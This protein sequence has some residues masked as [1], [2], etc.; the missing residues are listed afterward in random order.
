MLTNPLSQETAREI[1]ALH[2]D[3]D[4][5][6]RLFNPAFPLEVLTPISIEESEKICQLK[7]TMSM[8]I[9][10][11][12]ALDGL[13]WEILPRIGVF[14]SQSVWSRVQ[15]SDAYSRFQQ[16]GHLIWAIKQPQPT[17]N[18]LLLNHWSQTVMCITEYDRMQGAR[19][20]EVTPGISGSLVDEAARQ[21]VFW[22]PSSLEMELRDQK[23]QVCAV[24]DNIL[25]GEVISLLPA[26]MPKS[27]WELIFLCLISS[28][29][30]K[31]KQTFFDTGL[32]PRQGLIAY[33]RLL[34]SVLKRT[35]IL[36]GVPDYR[37]IKEKDLIL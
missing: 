14:N 2:P 23:W 35:E 8:S 10:L 6:Y 4:R 29:D 13:P 19:G 31:T 26:E 30:E 5:F 11:R 33:L 27:P 12:E 18:S 9:D 7:K 25:N 16:T 34:E 32:S 28:Q 21:Y 3:G 24:S 15:V 17:P 20:F 22:P 36:D 37:K 1:S